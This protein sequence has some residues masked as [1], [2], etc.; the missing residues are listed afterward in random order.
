MMGDV[1]LPLLEKRLSSWEL[2][3][4]GHLSE[5]TNDSFTAPKQPSLAIHNTSTA[6]YASM[7]FRMAD[8]ITRPDSLQGKI[9]LGMPLWLPN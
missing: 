8:S 3:A 5:K 4:T 7:T 1:I 9:S 2:R 6:S